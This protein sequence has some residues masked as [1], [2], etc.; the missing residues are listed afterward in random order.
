MSLRT[1]LLAVAA[2]V[3]MATVAVYCSTMEFGE[4]PAEGLSWFGNKE[5]IYCWYADES[6]SNY[7][8]SAAVSF[9][10][11][12]GVRVIPM[13]ISDSEYLEAINEASL[14]SEQI[15]DVYLLSND[16]L[17]KAYLAGLTSEI[18]D[19]TTCS[20]E[21]FPDAALS[22]VTYEGKKI[23]YPLSYETSILVYNKTYLE[24]WAKQQALKEI[25]N[26]G[27]EASEEEEIE[28]EQDAEAVVDET[29][30]AEL[31]KKYLPQAVPATVDRILQIAD[32]FD[33]PEGVEG[34]MKW[35]VSDVFYN[36]WFVGEYLVMGGDAGDNTQLVNINNEETVECLNAYKTLNQFFSIE[37]DT[38]T[39]DSV[40]SDFVSGKIVFTIATT[41]IV[42]RLEE[43]KADGSFGYEYGIAPMPDVSE[44]LKSRTMSVTNVAV[45]NGYT[46]HKELANKFAAYVTDEY[47]VSLYERTG[48]VAASYRA[49]HGNA[50]LQ[51]LMQ[52]YAD[53][54]PLPKMLETGNFW[55]HLEVL[56]AKIWN[57]TDVQE[58]L[59]ELAD[60]MAV[61]LGE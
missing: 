21:N 22:A 38:I 43:A 46:E 58:A 33:V 10:E 24:E 54:I 26:G 61:Q 16:S 45:V 30:V 5:T 2:V 6:M 57:G 1:K 32:S 37:S 44:E 34:V 17:G 60:Q 19:S 20:E 59:Q 40:V 28:S 12:E 42:K 4:K 9:G 51:I 8:N 27:E 13:L 56:F 48:K 25:A 31:T 18:T 39:Y 29:Q 23:G 49:N 55:M 14:H 35:D 3:A 53:S 15:P 41:D 36:Y 52:E 7:L 47:S 50:A 11:Q